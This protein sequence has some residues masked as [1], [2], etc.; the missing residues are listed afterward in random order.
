RNAFH[1][2]DARLQ[3]RS[4]A[5]WNQSLKRPATLG[6]GATPL[7]AAM[8]PKTA[9][10]PHHPTL[11]FANSNQFQTLLLNSVWL[12]PFLQVGNSKTQ[13]YMELLPLLGTSPLRQGELP[14]LRQWKM[15]AGSRMPM[16]LSIRHYRAGTP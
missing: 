8:N 16:R 1:R 5:R 3:S 14:S 6:I 4:L 13:D 9:S 2:R 7:S 15:L 11:L 10:N 12:F